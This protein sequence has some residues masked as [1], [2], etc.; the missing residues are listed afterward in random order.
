MADLQLF[1]YPQQMPL[2]HQMRAQLGQVPFLKLG[3]AMEQRLA[4]DQPEHG[5]S[6][7]L[8]HFIIA[9]RLAQRFHLARLRA[10]SQ[11]LREQCRALEAVTEALFK[12][13]DF[14]F[15]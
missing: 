2:A 7:K 15:V 11:R 6:Q 12:R 3:E 5:I 8:K 9:T 1:G 14:A 10:V 4:G 13:H